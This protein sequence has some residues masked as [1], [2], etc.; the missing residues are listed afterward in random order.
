MINTGREWDW[1][2]VKE[3]TIAIIPARWGSTRLPGK[4]LANI[5]GK[6]MIQWVYEAVKKS[7]VDKVV[8][9]TDHKDILKEVE[10]FGGEAVMTSINNE[11]G[12]ERVLE[13]YQKYKN[14][15]RYVI[16]I[17]GDEPIINE[18]D[19]NSIIWQLNN[20]PSR[21]ATLVGQLTKD[22]GIDRNTVKAIIDNGDIIMFTRSPSVSFSVMVKR[23]IGIYGFSKAMSERIDK[24]I[25]AKTSNEIAENLE[26][27]RW[28]D[29]G[30]RFSYTFAAGLY[31]GIDT[32]KDLE[33]VRTYLN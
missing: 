7:N 3:K 6:T 30:I 18:N 19:I 20:E 9:A 25:M 29:N 13:A 2:D 26:Q 32:Q 31:K 17:Q 21:I 10:R 33:K 4:P 16:N 15:Y 27:I 23:H 28:S 14:E 1:M 12:T 8:I 5:N 11:T 24:N 22:Q